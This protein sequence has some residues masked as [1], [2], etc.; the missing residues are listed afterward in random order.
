MSSVAKV[1]NVNTRIYLDQYNLSGFLNAADLGVKQELAV[2]TAFSDSGPR[3]VVGNYD[4]KHDHT[5]FFDGDAASIDEIIHNLIDGD[6]HYLLELFGANVDGSVAYESI[7]AMGEKPLLAKLGGAVLLNQAYAGRNA[8]SRG[9]VLAN[10]TIG[11]NGNQSGQNQGTTPANS[12]Y[13]AIVR[14]ISGGFTSFTVNIQESSDNGGADP[15]ATISGMSQA[16]TGAGAWRLTTTAATEA[17]KRVNIA[18]WIG[19]DAVV[20]VT[21]GRVQGT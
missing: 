13:Q 12:T 3:R 10:A 19:T 2:V 11:G 20:L 4:H 8:M 14:V 1:A 9:L 18:S 5:G 6:D 7:V 16:V 17:W 15:Y 21:G